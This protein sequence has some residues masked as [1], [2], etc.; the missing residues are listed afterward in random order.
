MAS[1]KR[2]RRYSKSLKDNF[3]NTEKYKLRWLYSL[4]L[5]LGL[6]MSV[7]LGS[8]VLS[9]LIYNNPNHFQIP[10]LFLLESAYVF[11]MCIFATK[12]AA[13]IFNAPLLEHLGRKY[14]RSGLSHG[15]AEE[16]LK[17]IVRHVTEQKRYMDNEFS[18]AKLSN[19]LCEVPQH[20]SQALNE[21]LGKNFY[22][23]INELR[24]DECK[25]KLA[26]PENKHKNVLDIA[27][28][29]GFNNKSSFNTAF[30]KHTNVTPSEFR[31]NNS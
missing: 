8:T 19:E 31:K 29:C 14:D 1:L 22:D 7:D 12:Q 16:I 2:L 30:K 5:G 25:L 6:L 24:V 18:L 23:F 20:L 27:F 3:A 10:Y 15:G 11:A 26:A 21:N 28:E 17:K 4:V 9:M 13:I